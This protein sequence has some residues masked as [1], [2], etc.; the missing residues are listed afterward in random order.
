MH[1]RGRGAGPG[2]D[3]MVTC[4][5]PGALTI[6]LYA[7]PPIDYA[8]TPIDYASTPID[9]ASTPIEYASPHQQIQAL[10]Y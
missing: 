6:R 8:S 9:Y 5:L 7:S 10:Q 1:G 4:Q 3:P 2:I